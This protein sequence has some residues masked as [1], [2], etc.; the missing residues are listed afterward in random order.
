MVPARYSARADGRDQL[1]S[2]LIQLFEFHDRNIVKWATNG[3]VALRLHR[4]TFYLQTKVSM[5][6]NS[7]LEALILI[8]P[9]KQATGFLPDRAH[10]RLTEG[11]LDPFA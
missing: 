3:C 5:N 9:L 6:V 1:V 7:S 8:N 11:V 4:D 2:R 10:V